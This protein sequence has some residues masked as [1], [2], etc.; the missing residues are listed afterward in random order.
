ME[1]VPNFSWIFGY[2]NISWTLKSTISAEYLCR[3]FKHMEKYN[4]EVVTPLDNENNTV[5]ENI[6]GLKSGYIQRDQHFLPRQGKAYPWKVLM[7]Y[8]R[9][10]KMLLKD[11]VE[12]SRLEFLSARQDA[13]KT[14][15][16]R[17]AG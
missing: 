9:D 1:N 6:L 11:P 12:D 2:T 8:G 16:S 15:V 7:H 17:V 14:Q 5:N 10:K 13:Y 3:L 4:L